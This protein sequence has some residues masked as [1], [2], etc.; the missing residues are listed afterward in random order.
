[1]VE[2][3]ENEIEEE[4][5]QSSKGNQLKFRRNDTWY[6][7]D[8]LGY[9]GLA[10]YVISKL[11]KKSTLS[12]EEYVDYDLDEIS[13]KSNI[14]KAC[15]STDFTDG[16]ELITLE[17]LFKNTYGYGLNSIIYK[18]PD[19]SDRLKILTQ[20]VERTTGIKDF[21]IY[22]SKLLTIDAFFLN[23]DRH[24]HNIA[25][26]TKGGNK[27]KLAPVFDNGAG[28][29]S[30]TTMDYPMGL[31]PIDIIK[32]VRSKTFCDS[33]DEQLDIAEI[34]YGDNLHFDFD[35]NDVTSIMDNADI[36]DES[37]KKRVTTI[38]MQQRHKYT[39]LFKK[40]AI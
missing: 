24:T 22:M 33:F 40:A 3:F 39:Y 7:A 29:C 25:V 1:M 9:E 15:K 14:Y 10:E 35:Y 34:L 38:I 13:Y 20:Q 27:F 28:L 31:N 32:T 21:G 6:K 19:R 23:E 2:L 4:N 30:D 8:Y 12:P 26:L 16:W 11:L 5:R 17:R 37:V 36:Y 18:T